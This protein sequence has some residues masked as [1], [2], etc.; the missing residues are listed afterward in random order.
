MRIFHW[1]N[2][3]LTYAHGQQTIQCN[4]K[5]LVT[6]SDENGFALFELQKRY[7]EKRTISNEM[8]IKKNTSER[9]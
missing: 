9:T 4:K 6:I 8:L 1:T 5:V 2:I 3:K 7:E